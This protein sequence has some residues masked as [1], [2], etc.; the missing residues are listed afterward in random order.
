MIVMNQCAPGRP[1]ITRMST[2]DAAIA[3]LPELRSTAARDTP[4]ATASSLR[5]GFLW[6]AGANVVYAACQW[7]MLTTLAKTCAPSEVGAFA[8]GLAIA[9]PV[10][11]FTSLQLRS[12]QATDAAH[13]YRLRDYI[14]LRI[15]TTLL[16]LVIIAVICGRQRAWG[17][18]AW[19]VAIIGFSKALEAMSDVLQGY[20]QQ[21]ERMQIIARSLIIK[22][23]LGF[24]AVVL[25]VCY[26]RNAFSAA[27]ALACTAA[28]VLTFYD[29]PVTKR[30]RAALGPQAG[31]MHDDASPW[32]RRKHLALWALPLGVV[33]GLVSLNA[34]IPRYQLERSA[35]L[36]EVGIF[37]AL[38][39][40]I[41]VGQTVV[42]ALGNVTSPRLAKLYMQGE[43]RRFAGLLG[44][45]IAVGAALGLAGTL[46]AVVAGRQILTVLFRP[47]YAQHGDALALVM[48]GGTVAYV[49]WFAGFGLTAAQLFREQVPLLAVVCA[50]A[51][52]VSFVAIPRFGINGAAIAF[53]C[54]MGVQAIG[55]LALLWWALS[56][57]R[58]T[59]LS[60]AL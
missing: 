53:L 11:S 37:S 7:G 28:L 54:S 40:L 51:W 17:L 14:T 44:K 5:S 45:L 38:A 47:E 49:A 13:R 4:F 59:R 33:Q 39:S 32:R 57:N 12:V 8:L 29:W 46:F 20:L 30:L 35:G 56:K 41:V 24:S 18:T 23:I 3:A 21:Q 58:R 60:V 27:L 42:A 36:A 22:G 9:S 48:L 55:A 10:I 2:R 1:A 15:W 50:V 19:V 34:N 52:V 16:A 31:A 25:A 6:T 26:F 43:V